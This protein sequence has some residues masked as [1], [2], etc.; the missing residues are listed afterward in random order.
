[1]AYST[2]TADAIV[3]GFV[4]VGDQQVRFWYEAGAVTP[5][6]DAEAALLTALADRGLVTVTA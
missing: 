6:S 3:C 2:Y 5:V 4:S 1:M